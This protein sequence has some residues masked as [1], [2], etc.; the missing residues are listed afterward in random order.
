VAWA[1]KAGKMP[2][3]QAKF[4]SCGMGNQGGQDAH[5]TSK[6]LLL[7]HGRLARPE[8]LGARS[9]LWECKPLY[10]QIGNLQS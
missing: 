9:Q 5:P 8:I 4:F 1:T 2:T 10:L 3:P 6:I 7:W